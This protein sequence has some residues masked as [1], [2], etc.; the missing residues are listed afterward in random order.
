MELFKMV[1]KTHNRTRAEKHKG[2]Q[3]LEI[4][5]LIKDFSDENR[6]NEVQYQELKFELID[7]NSL[8]SQEYK[9]I[10]LD[11]AKRKKT[12]EYCSM[13]RMEP[14]LKVNNSMRETPF[15]NSRL[16]ESLITPNLNPLGGLNAFSNPINNQMLNPIQ[17]MND[18]LTLEMEHTWEKKKN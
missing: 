8:T 17:K 16:T 4:D 12:S 14:D 1:I 18:E 2:I 5:Q 9:E 3:F 11:D 6:L 15:N 7:K 10:F 13:I